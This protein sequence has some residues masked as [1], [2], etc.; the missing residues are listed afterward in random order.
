VDA[1]IQFALVDGRFDCWYA[2]EVS[3]RK[4]LS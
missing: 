3:C 4:D 1:T 2:L